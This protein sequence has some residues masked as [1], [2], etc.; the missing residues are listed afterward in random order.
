MKY[1]RKIIIHTKRVFP[2]ETYFKE[3]LDEMAKTV[4]PRKTLDDIVEAGRGVWRTNDG[5][6]IVITTYELKGDKMI[7][8]G[9]K[10]TI[11]GRTF[12]VI[13]E[14]KGRLLKKCKCPDCTM[15][16][17]LPYEQPPCGCHA[18]IVIC[19]CKF[20]DVECRR[21]GKL[22]IRSKTGWSQIEE[23]PHGPN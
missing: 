12:T 22:W 10:V 14:G 18:L 11:A 17:Q 19:T 3:W 2:D 8:T 4:I 5:T 13:E 21:C 16:G 15:D 9:N 20:K 1:P 23:D 6:N 7:G